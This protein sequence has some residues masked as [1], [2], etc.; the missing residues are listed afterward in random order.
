[1]NWHSETAL[2]LINTV[3]FFLL[4]LFGPRASFLY[5]TLLS[6]ANH[7]SDV[8]PSAMLPFEVQNISKYQFTWQKQSHGRNKATNS[9]SVVKEMVDMEY[10]KLAGL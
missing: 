7:Q 3:A 6:E 4:Q 1:M 8:S 5:C 2:E 10:K 9:F